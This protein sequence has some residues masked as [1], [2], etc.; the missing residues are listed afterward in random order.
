MHRGRAVVSDPL[1]VRPQLVV[2]ATSGELLCCT[3]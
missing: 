1:R 3:L 2:L